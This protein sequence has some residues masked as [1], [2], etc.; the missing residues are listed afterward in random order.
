MADIYWVVKPVDKKFEPAKRK[1]NLYLDK[2]SEATFKKAGLKLK[3]K[4][5]DDGKDADVDPQALKDDL[6]MLENTDGCWDDSDED[7][8]GIVRN[9]SRVT[10]AT[11]SS[12]KTEEDEGASSG[13]LD[14]WDL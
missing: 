2:A 11:T 7:D 4:E 9:Y 3:F 1:T 14:A 8:V 5:D 6:A 12:N 13:P 10:L